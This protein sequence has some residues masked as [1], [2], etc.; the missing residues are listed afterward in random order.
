LT[1]KAHLDVV[2]ETHEI[3]DQFSMLGSM[4]LWIFWP[5]F[6]SAVVP[7]EQMPQTAINTVLALCGATLVTYLASLLMRRG[8]LGCGDM[9]NAALAG[10]VS[11]GA[12]CNQVSPL[13]AFVIGSAAGAICVVGYTTIQPA[14]QKLLKSVDTCGVHN[15]HGMPGLFGG[16]IAV[17]VVP[18][19]A[20]AQFAGIVVTVVLALV[21]GT[22]AGYLIRATGS[23]AAP[24]ED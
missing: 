4:V 2:I 15:L 1:S 19:I 6:C 5:S 3:P 18:G 10:G 8:L 16:A 13:V 24:Y 14:L 21:S 12:T 7:P 9:A 22:V 20:K 17:L 23:K 11:I